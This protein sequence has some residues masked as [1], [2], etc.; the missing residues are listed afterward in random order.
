MKK[1]RLISIIILLVI[2]LIWIFRPFSANRET[3]LEAFIQNFTN[4]MQGLTYEEQQALIRT[5]R[6][7]G[8]AIDFRDDE[9][10]IFTHAD[11][12]TARINADG[13]LVFDSIGWDGLSVQYRGNI[14]DNTLTRLLPAPNFNIYVSMGDETSYT[15]V[16]HNVT[17][18]QIQRYVELC[19]ALGFTIN[20]EEGFCDM[21][22]MLGIGMFIFVAN[23]TNGNVLEITHSQSSVAITIKRP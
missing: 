14:S 18:A 17:L 19:K 16:A 9:S 6:E 23:D 7:Q 22:G 8:V 2:A 20:V 12:S 15:I 13:T 3:H 4:E 11:G 21:L 10:V 1:I 5:G